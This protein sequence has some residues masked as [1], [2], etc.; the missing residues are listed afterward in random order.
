MT[1]S[2][3]LSVSKDA[4]V[5]DDVT[6]STYGT[7][8]TMLTFFV[9]DASTDEPMDGKRVADI[10]KS[11][12]GVGGKISDYK[13]SAVEPLVCRNNCSEHGYCDATTKQCVCD[14]FWVGN[15]FKSKFGRRESNCE[16]S[17]LYLS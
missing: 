8:G 11:K 17:L 10:L 3:L 5:V 15:I 14:S 1:V 9:R 2:K 4:V 12:L 16:W 7:S 13:L 6:R